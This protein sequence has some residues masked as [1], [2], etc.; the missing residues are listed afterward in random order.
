MSDMLEAG[1]IVG[2]IRHFE[3]E[4]PKWLERQT[5]KLEEAHGSSHAEVM[6][7][8]KGVNGIIAPWNFPIE[9]A[10]VMVTDMFAAGNTAI[11]KP[12]ELAPA[13]ANVLEKV[14]GKAVRSSHAHSPR[15][16]G[17]T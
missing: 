16:P 13:C 1:S 2:R 5:V 17:T 12:S 9:C 4:L 7:V 14:V 15:C 11:I 10:L 8:P 6:I 3:T